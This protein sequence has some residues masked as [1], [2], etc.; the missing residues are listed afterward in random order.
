MTPQVKPL[1]PVML[2]IENQL[3]VIVGGGAVAARKVADLLA[4]GA[5]VMV[6]SPA[7]HPTLEDAGNTETIIIQR[8]LYTVGLLR[9]LNPKPLLVFAATDDPALNAQIAFDARAIGSLVDVLDD[10]SASD[11]ASMAQIRRG[12]ISI[13]ISTSGASPALSAHLREVIELVFGDEY[14][15]LAAWMR[16]SRASIRQAIHTQAERRNLW[17]TV[18]DS[19]V[20]DHLRNG[21]TEVARKLYDTLL[22]ESSTTHES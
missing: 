16:E 6:I 20:L 15:T 7:L 3:C 12:D 22:S 11:F 2:R 14:A 5:Q 18:I 4:A 1:Y 9:G 21:D 17:H 8:E 13:A 19:A 10:A